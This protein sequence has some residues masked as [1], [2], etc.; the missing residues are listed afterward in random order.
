MK[1][2]FMPRSVWGASCNDHDERRYIE[3]E[4]DILPT[5]GMRIHFERDIICDMLDAFTMD[6]LRGMDRHD[7]FASYLGGSD[8]GLKMTRRRSRERFLEYIRKWSPNG[9]WHVDYIEYDIEANAFIVFIT[10]D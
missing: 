4:M 5:V 3:R 9:E 1:V 10:T 6:E 8:G 2:R 7:G